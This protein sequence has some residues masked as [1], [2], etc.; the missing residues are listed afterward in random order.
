MIVNCTPHD[1]T[2]LDEQTRKPVVVYP[3]SGTI[4]RCDKSQWQTRVIDGVPVDQYD[5]YNPQDIPPPKDGVIYIVSSI[6]A[7]YSDRNDIVIPGTTIKQDGR[8]I[9]CL[10]FAEKPIKH[11]LPSTFSEF[12]AELQRRFPVEF[13]NYMKVQKAPYKSKRK[14]K[15]RK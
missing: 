2:I 9:G 1:I 15:G 10:R 4:A 11:E 3:M 8:T 7:R 12:V 13:K 14:Y 6:V 5:Y